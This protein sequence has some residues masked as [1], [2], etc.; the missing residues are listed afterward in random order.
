MQENHNAVTILSHTCIFILMLYSIM[1]SYCI[2]FK[3]MYFNDFVVYDN[4]IY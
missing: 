2:L 4:Y 1:P 3:I